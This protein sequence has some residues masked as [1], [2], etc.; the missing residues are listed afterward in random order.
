[1]PWYFRDDDP[2]IPL[3]F[4]GLELEMSCSLIWPQRLWPLLE[5]F[6]RLSRFFDVFNFD[7]LI[8]HGKFNIAPASKAR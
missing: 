8:Y 1:M 7:I 2:W 4:T 3:R 5:V 6:H